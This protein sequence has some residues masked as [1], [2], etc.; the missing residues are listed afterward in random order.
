MYLQDKGRGIVSSFHF[1]NPNQALIGEHSETVGGTPRLR[2]CDLRDPRRSKEFD[3]PRWP[4]IPTSLS[5]VRNV[6]STS[7]VVPKHTLFYPD[8]SAR[9]LGIKLDFGWQAP[10]KGMPEH[11]LFVIPESYFT[12]NLFRSESTHDWFSHCRHVSPQR[13]NGDIAFVGRWLLSSDVDPNHYT[14]TISLYDLNPGAT[15]NAGYS[16]GWQQHPRDNSWQAIK[17]ASMASVNR[18]NVPITM[19]N[20][21]PNVIKVL[22]TED[23]LI[24]FPVRLSLTFSMILGPILTFRP[25]GG[26]NIKILTF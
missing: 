24:L 26:G 14:S 6:S 8:P 2:A 10:Q 9:L 15:E 1:L 21:R 13:G 12:V 20:A 16:G 7:G 3:F 18:K 11:P 4:L 23:N 19:T 22:A 5:F 25:Q 17:L